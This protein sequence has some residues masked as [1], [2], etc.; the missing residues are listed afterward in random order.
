MS[1]LQGAVKHLSPP[2]WD[3]RAIQYSQTI[4]NL[5]QAPLLRRCELPYKRKSWTN[6]VVPLVNSL[7]WSPISCY[8]VQAILIWP[9]VQIYHKQTFVFNCVSWFYEVR[10]KVLFFNKLFLLC[11]RFFHSQRTL[12][13][14]QSILEIVK[15]ESFFF[16]G[17]IQRKILFKTYFR[18]GNMYGRND[19]L[20]LSFSLSFAAA[21]L[22]LSLLLSS[23]NTFFF[24]FTF[25]S[26]FLICF[27]SLTLQFNFFS[28]FFLFL[29]YFC[30]LRVPNLWRALSVI[31]SARSFPW[32]GPSC[33]SNPGRNNNSYTK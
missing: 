29:L 18:F 12:S 2:N 9:H 30:S 23:Y 25:L 21:I 15:H 20:Y 19:S 31:P 16:F 32:G 1:Y 8:H 24:H 27:N 13:L 7:L 6:S 26:L 28:L 4:S 33:E 14:Y 11:R 10:K 5:C 17:I 3:W 22:S